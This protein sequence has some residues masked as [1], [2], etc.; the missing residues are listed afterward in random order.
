[1]KESNTVNQLIKRVSEDD[2]KA[3]ETLFKQ[4]HK[5]IYAFALHLVQ[6]EYEAEEI[7]QDVFIAI[8]NQRK[9]LKISGF[10]ISYLFGITRHKTYEYIQKKI[11]HEA[12]IKYYLEN[13]VDYAFITEEEILFREL[14]NKIRKL[15]QSLPARRS[16]IFMLSRQDGL[17]YKEIADKLDISE[18]TVDTQIRHALDF[19][20]NNFS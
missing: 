8:W 12:F 15:I 10:F 17:S 4:Y 3:F 6:S 1:M 19:L 14:E 13:N 2:H 11:K 20:R 7:V 9:N 5:R 16:E 18:N